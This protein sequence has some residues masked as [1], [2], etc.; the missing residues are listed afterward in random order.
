MATAEKPATIPQE[1]PDALPKAID[2]AIQ[3]V[4]DSKAA[5]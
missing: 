5:R 4:G 3:G 1:D 2:G